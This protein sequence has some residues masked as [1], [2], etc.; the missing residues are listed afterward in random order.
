MCGIAAVFGEGA[1]QARVM[2][3]EMLDTMHHRGPDESDVLERHGAA[4]GHKRLA[5]MAPDDGMQPIPN[6]DGAAWIVCNGEIYNHEFLREQVLG[7]HHSFARGSDSEVV[8]H[9]YEQLGTAAAAELDGMFAFVIADW[10]EGDA[11]IYAARDP[12]GIKP[13]YYGHTSDGA[14][15]FASELKSLYGCA[16]DIREFPAGHWYRTGDGF[17]R[18]EIVGAP[19][20]AEMFPAAG[21]DAE[22]E[23]GVRASLENAVRKW[24]MSDV[25]VGVLLSGGLDSSLVS[26]IAV[27][28]LAGPVDSFCVGTAGS[29]DL[30]AARDVAAHLGTRHHEHEFTGQEL[31]DALPDVIYH[32]ESFDPSLVRSAIPCHFVS[33]LAAQHVKVVLSGEGADELF[34]GYDYLQ[35]IDDEEALQREL[36]RVLNSLHNI[37]L[38]RL[39]RMSMAHALEGRVPFLD[40]DLV[41]F[42]LRIPARLKATSDGRMEKHILRSA[43]TGSGLLPDHILWR[44]KEEFST[45]SGAADAIEVRV[46]REISADELDRE[47][48]RVRR[49]YG[50]EIRSRQELHCFRIFT[51]LFPHRSAVDTVGRWPV[52]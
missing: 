37:N 35:L 46:Q 44:T 12:L 14:L 31:W 52:A 50:L 16:H 36:V 17:V 28:E 24:L 7:E 40:R 22:I 8:L 48:R 34:S 1:E 27:R 18:Y 42:A 13:L 47:Q 39:D 45:G 26:A 5:I 10:R 25:P 11:V 21:Y 15:V 6:E 41:S 38:Q 32:L 20:P 2:L 51:E 3:G 4:L 30:P 9:L 43:F 33:R 23:A 29:A 19:A 49:A